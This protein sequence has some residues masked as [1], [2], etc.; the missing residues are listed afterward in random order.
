MGTRQPDLAQPLL[1]IGRMLPADPIEAWL[2]LR[3]G[4]PTVGRDQATAGAGETRHPVADGDGIAF[5]D[6]GRGDDHHVLT[7]ALG[8]RR[9][10]IEFAGE[11]V[12]ARL[13]RLYERIVAAYFLRQSEHPESKAI[14]LAIG[15]ERDEPRRR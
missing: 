12:E 2:Q 10:Y 6:R 3:I 7:V 14:D 1:K 11:A 8:S 13:R 9:A 4:P 15:L 5:R